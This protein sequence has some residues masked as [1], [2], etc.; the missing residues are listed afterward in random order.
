MPDTNSFETMTTIQ[1]WPSPHLIATKNF[2]GYLEDF[3]ALVEK[4]KEKD[5]VL[6]ENLKTTLN[7]IKAIARL[8]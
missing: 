5:A 4:N 1:Y 7:Y 8:D 3:E 2:C 6:Y